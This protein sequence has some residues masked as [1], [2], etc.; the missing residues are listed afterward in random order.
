MIYMIM[1]IASEKNLLS[2]AITKSDCYYGKT[3]TI[4]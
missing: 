4:I 2:F 1:R 3:G